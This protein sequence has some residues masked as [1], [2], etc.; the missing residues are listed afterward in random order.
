MKRLV[1]V[2]AVTV[3]IA[4]GAYAAELTRIASSFEENDPFGMFLDVGFERTRQVSKLVREH[5]QYDQVQDVS[6]LIYHSYDNRLNLALRVGLWQDFEFRYMLPIVFTQDRLWRY[7]KD[8]DASIST[9][10]N[11]CLQANGDLLDPGCPTSG[12]GRRGLFDI[13]ADGPNSYRGG[14]GDMTFGLA[15][16]FFN[17]KKDPSKPTWIVGVDY[18]APTSERLEPTE[19]TAPDDRGGIG[20]RLHRYKFYTSLSKRLGIA[21]P[22]FQIHY[23]LPYRGPGWY[24]NCENR[25][26]ETMGLPDNCDEWSRLETGIRP[27]HVGGIIFGSEFNA[28]DEPSKFQKV[29]LDLRGIAT[30]VSEGRY[31]NEMSDLFH[32][33]LYT[34]DYLQVGGSVGFVAHAAEFVQ[35]RATATLLYNTEHNLTDE[36]IGK[37]LSGNGEVELGSNEVN[38]NF[39]W[40][41]DLVSRRFRAVETSVFRLDL[42]ASFNF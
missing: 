38:P 36:S 22:Y 35:L 25:S 21:D 24:S 30:Y 18:T 34:S 10:T 27:T 5:H 40:R 6:E 41:V 32:K 31:Y 9:I 7:S 15:Y 2:L 4:P 42:S 14:M 28:Y 23:T 12:A 8:S 3:G 39:D 17:E 19:L 13:R 29:A 20:D 26:Q 37:D 1:V 33:L 11:N 16:A